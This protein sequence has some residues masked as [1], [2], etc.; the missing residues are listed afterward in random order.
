MSLKQAPTPFPSG[1][2]LQGESLPGMRAPQVAEAHPRDTHQAKAVFSH[3]RRATC[4][5]VM[6][7]VMLTSLGDLILRILK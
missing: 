7:A 4:H 1:G 5:V 6:G 3:G 2:L